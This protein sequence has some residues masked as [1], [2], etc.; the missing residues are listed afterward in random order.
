MYSGE[1]NSPPW[2]LP[3]A[4]S[5]LSKNRK[6]AESAVYLQFATPKLS[7]DG[8]IAAVTAFIRKRNLK[9]IIFDPAYTSLLKG[10]TKASASNDPGRGGAQPGDGHLR[11]RGYFVAS[12]GN[13]TDEV[14]MENIKQ[15]DGEATR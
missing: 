4:I 6:S 8:D 15:Q 12:S 7:D 10:N 9:V 11:V 5:W 2:P 14:I 3:S 1:S 13:V